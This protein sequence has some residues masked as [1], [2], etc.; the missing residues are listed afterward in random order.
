MYDFQID[1]KKQRV[2]FTGDR[3]AVLEWCL[4]H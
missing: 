1:K 4:S 3:A 2:L